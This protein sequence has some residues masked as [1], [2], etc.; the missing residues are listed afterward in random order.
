MNF[1]NINGITLHYKW[2][3]KGSNKTFV[4]INSLGTDFRIWNEVVKK[5]EAHGNVLLYDKRG[6]GLSDTATPANGLEGFADD[7]WHLLKHLQIQNCIVIG[8]SVGGIIAQWLTHHHPNVVEKLILCDTRHKIG[9]PEL[10]NDRIKQIKE[11]G[12]KSISDDLMK[13]WFAPYFHQSSPTVVQGC[14]NMVER[15]D[16]AGYVQTCEGIRDADTTEIAK[17][18]RKKTL[19]VVGSEDK[20]TTP[21]EMKTLVDLIEGSR[22]EVIEGSGH[23]PCVDNPEALVKLI[24]DFANE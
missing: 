12:L 19:C 13:R 23:I 11:T 24:V 14:K 5:V 21:E 22:Y 3:D 1:V 17:G 6:H 18:I 15:C 8:L 20:S 10:W 2:I 4:F 7:L 16:P 9:V